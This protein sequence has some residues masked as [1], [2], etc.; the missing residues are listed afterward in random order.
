MKLFSNWK[1]LI[2][3]FIAHNHHKERIDAAGKRISLKLAKCFATSVKS[4]SLVNILLNEPENKTENLPK[5]FRRKIII[6]FSSS[7]LKRE[8]FS[9]KQNYFNHDFVRRKNV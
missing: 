4:S 5:K 3:I 1:I 6:K 2:S 7:Y 9:H 8:R